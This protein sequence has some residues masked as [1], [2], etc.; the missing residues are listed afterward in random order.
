MATPLIID[1]LEHVLGTGIRP[2]AG[3]DVEL[4]NLTGRD[5][6]YESWITNQFLPLYPRTPAR[7]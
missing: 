2:R 5:D 4:S 1:D 6:D 3:G 7:R